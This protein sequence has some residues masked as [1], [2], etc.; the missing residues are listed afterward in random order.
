MRAAGL[1][2]AVGDEPSFEPVRFN[3]NYTFLAQPALCVK[4]QRARCFQ[5]GFRLPEVGFRLPH[6]GFPDPPV[7]VLP[8]LNPRFY[9]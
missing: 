9:R 8:H 1:G 6:E 3:V 2:V 7:S 4:V 5:V